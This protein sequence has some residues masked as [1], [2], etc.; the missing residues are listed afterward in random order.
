M[1]LAGSGSSAQTLTVEPL[2]NPKTS[3][4]V[5]YHCELAKAWRTSKSSIVRSPSCSFLTSN[6]S[7]IRTIL[8]LKK[9]AKAFARSWSLFADG[10]LLS[11]LLCSN[12][13]TVR[14]SNNAVLSPYRA[15]HLQHCPVPNNLPCQFQNQSNAIYVRAF[16][17][18]SSE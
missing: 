9:S 10:Y 3:S 17:F 12:L 16:A 2:I 14:K 6:S 8:A 18:S 5:C 7:R 15:Y 1:V 13:S 11:I 4:S